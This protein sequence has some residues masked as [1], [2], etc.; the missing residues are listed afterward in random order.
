VITPETPDGLY[1]TRLRTAV[2]L[3]GPGTSGAYHAGVLRALHEAGVRIDLVAGRGM[4]AVSAMFAAVDGGGRLWEPTGVW[5]GSAVRGF[6]RWRASLRVAAWCL[7]AS[8]LVLLFPLLL[9][10]LAVLVGMAGFLLTLVGLTG[11]GSSLTAGYASWI[12]TWFSPGALPLI[13]PRLVLLGVVLAAVAIVVRIGAGRMIR[14]VRRRST[15][16]LLW[17]LV[18]TPLCAARTVEVFA[19]ELWALIRGAAPLQQPRG[20]ELARRYVELLAENLGQPGFRELVVVLHDVDARQDLVAAFLAEPHR[21]RFFA[22]PA[23]GPGPGRAGEV[24]DLAGVGRDHAMDVLAASLAL[25][26]ATAPHLVTFPR[27]GPWRGETHRLCDR[28]G[29]LGRVLEEVAAAGAEQVILLSATPRAA[30]PHEMHAARGDVAGSAGEQL[31]A[32]EAAALRDVVE[33]FTGRFAG[34][35]VIRPDHNAVAPFDFG[36]SYD[37]RSDRTYTLGELVDRGYEDAYRQFID[38]VV[39][40]SGDRM[41]SLSAR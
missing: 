34:L 9:L 19:A 31:A 28:P 40:A 37:E 1:S 24:L 30:R 3:T 15:G 8:G 25:P 20:P 14:G 29:S 35:Y 33:Q 11:A 4:G 32:F 16:G 26:I 17:R 12:H 10:G 18:G 6:Y 36:G 2:V 5:R 27:E 22:R 39:G 38:P 13:V 23:P 41:Q 7:L 21:P